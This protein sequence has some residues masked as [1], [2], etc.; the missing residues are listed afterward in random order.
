[1]LPPDHSFDVSFAVPFVHKLRFTQNL[2]E[3]EE[4]VLLELLEPPEGRTARVQFWIDEGLLAVHPELKQRIWKLCRRHAAIELVGNVQVVPAGE[5][6]KNDVHLLEQMLKVIHA[7]GLDRQSYLVVVGGGAVLDAVGFAAAIAHRG[8][9]LIRIPTTTLSQAD[10]G[11][12]VKNGINL[13]QKK[14]WLG[15]FAVP[16]GVINDYSL[17]ESL[18]DRDFRAGFSE[19]VKVAL[20][21]EPAFFDW[22]CRESPRIAARE[23]DASRQAIR[24]S[25]LWHLRHITAG[26]DPFEMEE[27]R[28]LDYGHWSAHR[29]ESL[30]DFEL[31]HGEAVAIGVAI[32][33][34]Y[35]VLKHGLS[36]EQAERVLQ[37]LSNLGFRL[38]HRLLEQRDELFAG[39]EEFRQHL[40][41]RLTVTM[42]ADIGQPL[43]VHEVDL[44]LMS[45]AIDRVVEFVPTEGK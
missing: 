31:R 35:S 32:D 33:T 22:L 8:I 36:M 16:W 14:N 13:F 18:S 28:P 38:Q 23:S 1:M 25:A 42:L 43:D 40:G 45:E 24:Q 3:R 26:G 7:H 34:L 39:L 17:L 2:W 20:L 44:A 27:A 15:S 37:C 9:R 19:A 29:L 11:V 4:S 12:G 41:G 6:S 30:A 21:K 5:A 10:S